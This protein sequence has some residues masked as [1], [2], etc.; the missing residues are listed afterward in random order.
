[1]KIVREFTAFMV[2]KARKE[3]LQRGVSEKLVKRGITNLFPLKSGKYAFLACGNNERILAIAP[4]SEWEK[5]AEEEYPAYAIGFPSKRENEEAMAE[6]L[7]QEVIV[8]SITDNVQWLYL[9][10]V[11]ENQFTPAELIPVQSDVFDPI[12]HISVAELL[13]TY[14]EPDFPDKEKRLA[15]YREN[16][17]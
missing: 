2:K 12:K 7:Q 9:R 1:M 8:C 5:V 15:E 10:S 11:I 14:P 3:A 4:M 17:R 16:Y 13:A 6:L